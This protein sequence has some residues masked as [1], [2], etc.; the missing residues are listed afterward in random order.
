MRR[1]PA[2]LS[3]YLWI[4]VICLFG[5][6][7]T[8]AM[9][10]GAEAEPL[11][12]FPP[13]AEDYAG[14]EGL[15]L[16]DLLWRRVLAEPFNA[17]ATLIFFLAVIHTFLAG[18]FARIG[19]RLELEHK[20]KLA[21]ALGKGLGENQ[22]ST[23]SPKMPVSFRASMFHFLGEVEAVFGIW[24]LPLLVCMLGWS[25]VQ[26]F[27][28]GAG[29]F[30][31]IIAG[32]ETVTHYVDHRHF[33]EP[34]FVVVIMCA[35]ATRPV[36]RLAEKITGILAKLG[37]STPKAWWF[38]ALTVLPLLGSFITEPAAMTI[39]AMLLAR[40][41]YE[42]QPS[43]KFKYAT[44]A[45]LFVNVSVGGTLTHFAAPPVLMVAA[46][47]HLDLR[48]MVEH[49]G[50]KSAVGIVCST[51]AVACL[52]KAE[53]KELAKKAGSGRVPAS[54]LPI[55]AWVTTIHVLF[56]VWAV[57]TMHHPAM[58][59][60]GF[61]FFLAF[62]IA[63]EHHQLQLQLRGPLMV[64]FFLAALVVHGS[65]QNW[66]IG[67]ILSN[68]PPSGMFLGAT[69]L[70]AFNDNASIT[71]LASQVPALN[72]DLAVDAAALA[73]ARVLEYSVLT[74]AVAGGGLT[75]IA[76]APNP[77]GQNLLGKFFEGGIHPLHLLLAAIG[78]TVIM[79]LV[80]QVL[81]GF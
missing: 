40:R 33:N 34:L 45:L 61:L 18:K 52:F 65:L 4:A 70:T 53:F 78:P 10:S 22:A 32:W 26:A 59:I 66:W 68:L 81:P 21:A 49:I 48:M 28:Q 15:P 7:S 9:A 58:M 80:F 20:E 12:T 76:N 69:F 6:A 74:G 14:E 5:I 38:A 57:L 37:G 46:P 27:S 42:L 13:A 31:G 44:L 24:L 73:Q 43:N 1:V 77:A 79:A 41:F 55:P 39:A 36:L 2:D 67:P 63:T 75:V 62:L 35:A 19:H 56:L 8:C 54:K 51:F 3:V 30:G 25:G 29:L 47:W 64:G 11:I 23:E 71:F 17:V 72:P 50:W 16:G 60:G